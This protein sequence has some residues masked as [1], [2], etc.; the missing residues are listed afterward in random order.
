VRLTREQSFRARAWR[1]IQDRKDVLALS[2][3][4]HRLLCSIVHK[5][6]ATGNNGA[7]SLGPRT[8]ATIGFGTKSHGEK[9]RAEL[10]AAKLLEAQLD[11]HAGTY[12]PFALT[13]LPITARVH[14]KLPPRRELT[15]K[16]LPPEREQLPPEREV[17]PQLYIKTARARVRAS[18]E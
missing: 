17:K 13:F 18:T 3:S 7:L 2:N 15:P 1:D 8:L 5:V 14:R 16:K 9:A 10:I 6:L 12:T 4:A 11:G